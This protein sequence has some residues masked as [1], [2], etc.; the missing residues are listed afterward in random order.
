MPF[1]PIPNSAPPHG[2]AARIPASPMCETKNAAK[3]RI[4]GSGRS[5][6]RGPRPVAVLRLYR[7]PEA[8]TVCSLV[9]EP[10][11]FRAA[12]F[13]ARRAKQLALQPDESARNIFTAPW[14]VNPFLAQT[15]PVDD[16]FGRFRP[17]RS[18]ERRPQRPNRA[19]PTLRGAPTRAIDG[20]TT[21]SPAAPQPRQAMP[22]TEPLRPRSRD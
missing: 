20:S 1:H 16:D 13:G 21:P 5:Q 3:T 17:V 6:N 7:P 14:P 18:A 11:A 9:E 4:T 2:G 10:S 12:R 15:L 22:R 19:A 8:R